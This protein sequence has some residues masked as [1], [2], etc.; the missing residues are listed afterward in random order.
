[1]NDETG[2]SLAHTS[3]NGGQPEV[4]TFSLNFHTSK[5]DNAGL[6]NIARSSRGGPEG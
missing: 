2:R 4:L 6:S 1:M 3:G 5:T